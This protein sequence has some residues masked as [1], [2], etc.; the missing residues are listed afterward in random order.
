MRWRR[1]TTTHSLQRGLTPLPLTLSLLHPL[2]SAAANQG[3]PP[4]QPRST[5]R[6]A[7]RSLASSA[8]GL[9]NSSR[10]SP[11][12]GCSRSSSTATSAGKRGQPDGLLLQLLGGPDKPTKQVSLATTT[13]DDGEDSLYPTRTTT[14]SSSSS[15]DGLLGSL[16][17]AGLNLPLRQ[18]I[19]NPNNKWY[20]A[21]WGLLIGAAAFTGIFVPWELGFGD[22]ADYYS[23]SSAATWMD[24]ILVALFMA[25]IGER[26]SSRCKCK[27]SSS[28]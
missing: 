1:S 5:P 6:V 16:D 12:A 26:S 21:W 19:I 14:S 10:R 15:G 3:L 11:Q 4:L 9:P 25:D 17:S 20:R 28:N 23:L 22:M 8:V 2:L 7:P 27:C 24:M 13:F 18:G